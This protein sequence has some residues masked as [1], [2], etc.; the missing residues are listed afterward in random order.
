MFA[1]I[2]H[3]LLADLFEHSPVHDCSDLKNKTVSSPFA[4]LEN[5][6]MILLSPLPPPPPPKFCIT[7]VFSFSWELES[8]QKKLKLPWLCKMLFCGTKLR[9]FLTWPILFF[10]KIVEI[11]EFCY[12][13][14][15]TSHFSL[16]CNV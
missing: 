1:Q 11:Q 8:S 12:H 13:D 7:I 6:I 3:F 16:L 15:V 14:K 9:Y 10:H 4:T 5:T 2:W